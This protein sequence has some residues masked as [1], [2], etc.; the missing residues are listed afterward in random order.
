MNSKVTK[1]LVGYGISLLSLLCLQ[2][3]PD[4]SPKSDYDQIAAQVMVD[5]KPQL[6]GT[7]KLR[8]VQVSPNGLNRLN[9]LNLTKD[10]TFQDLAI[11]TI[12]PAAKP[13]MTPADPK[14]GE[15]DGTIQYKNKTYPIQFDMWPGPRVYSP[16]QQGPQAFLLFSY[17]FPD[18]LHVA[19]PEETFLENI[20]LI[21]ETFSLETT[22]G[23]PTLMRWVGLNREI[24][25][26]DF[27]KHP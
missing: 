19:E 13:R 1:K 21:N 11:L 10:S 22:A 14:R 15:Y 7:W 20:G 18:G 16:T 24:Q 27:V 17:R 5:L 25:Q 6:V 12:V 9:R 3:T 23:Q 26:I 4:A 2:C 8:Q